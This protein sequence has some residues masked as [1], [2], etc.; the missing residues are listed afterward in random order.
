VFG[1]LIGGRRRGRGGGEKKSICKGGRG[2]ECFIE[3]ETFL[4]NV[5][6]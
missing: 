6:Q 5:R 3:G 4:E 2:P 1:E